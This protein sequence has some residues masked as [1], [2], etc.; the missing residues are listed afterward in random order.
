M[1]SVVLMAY[2]IP[3][4]LFRWITTRRGEVRRY[5]LTLRS[6]FA[7]A[8]SDPAAQVRGRYLYKGKDIIRV[9]RQ[10]LRRHGPE[11]AALQFEGPEVR[12]TDEGYGDL[13]LLAAL[14]HPD[15][16]FTVTLQSP[17]HRRIA[18]VAADG[19]VNNVEFIE[20]QSL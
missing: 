18:S 4:L 20:S 17:E 13:A 10:N 15:Q 7:G 8:P 5:P 1:F 12:L 14:L 16:K 6:L 19:F 2:L 11:V 3:P 9:V